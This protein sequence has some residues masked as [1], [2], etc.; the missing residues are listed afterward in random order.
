MDKQIMKVRIT[1]NK[2]LLLFMF[3]LFTAISV[4][5]MTELMVT[6][7]LLIVL[8]SRHKARQIEVIYSLLTACIIAGLIA[9]RVIE[10]SMFPQAAELFSVN[11]DVL[12]WIGT[13]HVHAIRLLIVY[14]GVVLSK[15]FGFELNLGVTIYS[16]SLMTLIMYFMMR[17]MSISKL[18]NRI[19]A[20]VSGLFIIALSYFMNGRLIFVFFGISLLALYEL[21]FRENEVS[22]LM[23]Q[24]VTAISIVFT[25][26]SSGTMVIAF[27]YA[28][29]IMPYR[30]KKLRKASEKMVFTAIMLAGAIP[31][32]CIFVPY[33]IKMI[34]KN[35]IYYGGGFQGAIN[36][37]NHGIGKIVNTNDKLLVVSLFV[38]GA[39]VVIVNIY[40]FNH[41]IIR[42]DHP[43]LPLI[44]LVNLSV[45]GS[46][47]GLSTGLTALI[48]LLVL[49][50]EKMIKAFGLV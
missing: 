28:V 33:L 32:I 45:Y 15:L 20:M 17:M 26:V 46:I 36:M 23:L 44:L 41:K 34:E 31:V 35:I 48:P 12:Y 2:I 43:N 19:S 14:P 47:F 8:V 24:I 9:L 6:L 13:G 27:A 39:M 50:I 25:M 49:M 40:L 29:I 37:I 7:P 4:A 18:E 30:W 3:I 1:K 21:K 10:F 11:E 5:G 22:V 16:A 42:R 38:I